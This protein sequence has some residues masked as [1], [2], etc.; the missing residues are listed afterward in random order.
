MPVTHK[1]QAG[2]DIPLYVL[3]KASQ[4]DKLFGLDALYRETLELNK[5]QDEWESA[6]HQ[7]VVNKKGEL[8]IDGEGEVVLDFQV[9][10][11]RVGYGSPAEGPHRDIGI[12]ATSPIDSEFDFRMLMTA[13]GGNQLRE[14][15]FW[16]NAD[17]ILDCVITALQG[18]VVELRPRYH[19]RGLRMPHAA[20][21]TAC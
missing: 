8:V 10:G 13:F 2:V 18:L 17:G 19:I 4:A 14:K 7:L 20:S 12:Q 11:N 5:G 21:L 6:K 1:D 9:V 3:V 16:R 15:G